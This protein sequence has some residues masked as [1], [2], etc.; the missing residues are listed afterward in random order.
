MSRQRR[1]PRRAASRIT[2]NALCDPEKTQI[3]ADLET[4]HSEL[5]PE[6]SVATELARR[7][8]TYE[9]DGLDAPDTEAKAPRLAC[10][11]LCRNLSRWVGTT[12]S[13]ALLARAL[14]HTQPVH[15][16]LTGVR[17]DAGA[18]EC[19]VGAAELVTAHGATPVAAALESLIA[20]VLE[21]LGRLVGDDVTNQILALNEPDTTHADESAVSVESSESSES[22]SSA[23][24]LPK[25]RMRRPGRDRSR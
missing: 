19:V 1:P 15:P 10:E 23:L 20:S 17:I 25:S 11:R 2:R 24:Q 9:S 5:T 13:N 18:D 12:G 14:T 16:L 21:L 8:I 3:A 22:G 7:L 4:G 6:V